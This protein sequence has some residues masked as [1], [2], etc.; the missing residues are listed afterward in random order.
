MAFSRCFKGSVQIGLVVG[1][2]FLGIIIL[3]GVTMP[4]L[5]LVAQAKLKFSEKKT[6]QLYLVPVPRKVA[7]P[8]GRFPRGEEIVAEGLKLKVPWG[9]P[10]SSKKLRTFTGF[11]FAQNQSSRLHSRLD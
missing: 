9:K 8:E 5:W 4:Q 7:V 2:L 1:G 11:K 10:K 6:P 3:V